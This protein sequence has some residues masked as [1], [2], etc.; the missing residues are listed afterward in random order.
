M[1]DIAANDLRIFPTE[2]E[3]L[4][5]HELHCEENPLLS[6]LPVHSIQEEEV[7][8]LKEMAA[9]FVMSQLKD[10]LACQCNNVI[11]ALEQSNFLDPTT[12]KM[13]NTLTFFNQKYWTQLFY[14]K[15]CLTSILFHTNT[16][17]FI[18]FKQGIYIKLLAY[19]LYNE[20]LCFTYMYKV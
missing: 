8:S 16:W 6:H 12:K 13:H 15:N 5:L 4:P 3:Q 14:L 1:L 18:G 7:L 11:R 19:L 17:F 9:R 20:M 2:T 10:R